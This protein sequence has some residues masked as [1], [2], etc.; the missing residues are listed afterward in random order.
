MKIVKARI[1]NFR[2]IK[3]EIEVKF[4]SYCVIVG[5]N[6]A[7]KSTVLKAL[8]AFINDK[9][10]DKDSANVS[11][12]NGV[13]EIEL[14]FDPQNASVI[15]DEQ[16]ETTFEAEGLTTAEGYVVL[17]K[18]WNTSLSRIAS[19]FSFLR[20]KYGADDFLLLTEVQLMALCKKKGI[21]TSKGNGAEFNNVEKRGKLRE[22]L[23]MDEAAF[24]YEFEKPP[25]SGTSRAKNIAD[26]MK[27]MMPRFEYFKADSSL[28][29]TDTSIQNYFKK[30]A[31]QEIEHCE[32]ELIQ[33]RV[34]EKLSE[35][36]KSISG[37]INQ[38]V[39]Q[40]KSVEPEIKFDWTKLVQTAFRSKADE[41]DIPLKNR[42]DGFRRI[43][44]MAYFEHLADE[45]GK[46][47]AEN[48]I[49]GFEEPE[50]FLHP[51]AQEQ[52]FLRL[53][54]VSEGN[55]QVLVTTHSPV[56]VAHSDKD[57]L[58][59][60]TKQNGEVV[61]EQDITDY[62]AIVRDLGI[63]PNRMLL[64]HIDSAQLLL[65]VEGP[66]D[67]TAF[68]H[69]ASSYKSNGLIEEDF[70]D[71]GVVIVPVGGC[72]S[73]QHWINFNV[74][75]GLRKPFFIIL[76]SD[77]DAELAVS[78]NLTTLVANGLLEH[79][80]HILR[81][82]ALE[83]YIDLSYFIRRFPDFEVSFGPFDHV[84]TYSKTHSQ[85]RKLGGGKIADYHFCN[86]NIDELRAGMGYGGS[87]E[88]LDIVTALRRKLSGALEAPGAS[89]TLTALPP[90][91]ADTEVEGA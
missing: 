31:L 60:V 41:G 78:K 84:K 45:G 54:M 32:T 49:Y 44:M 53:K 23:Q 73:I 13:V 63:S 8:N 82:R 66:D 24:T 9:D 18:V 79:D 64:A 1:K 67:I 37:K 27:N 34:A 6:D 7:G 87:D 20:K 65:L 71:M 17:K 15:I 25:A 55:A 77:K 50:T 52:L 22:L 47:D 48:V 28:E 70:V 39:T 69:L 86:Q 2:G 58:I 83:N 35:V 40:T 76:D 75:R 10:I 42:G 21:D 38:V 72:D 16:V 74:I 81:K 43:T 89:F 33:N 3:D 26:I 62:S 36:M 57:K 12:D 14:Y 30:I 68:E 90:N 61:Y 51:S 46:G 5:Q 59:H 88:F 91:A 11:T 56:I 80:F 19:E 85:A 4:D 29:E